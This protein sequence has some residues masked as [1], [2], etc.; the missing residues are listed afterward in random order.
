MQT[1]IKELSGEILGSG[2]KDII[3][4]TKDVLTFKCSSCGAEVVVDTAS[5]TQA[6]CHWCRNISN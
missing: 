1:D 3:A 5:S 2:A 4:D 6:R